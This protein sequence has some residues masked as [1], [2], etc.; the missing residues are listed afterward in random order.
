MGTYHFTL[1]RQTT[2]CYYVCNREG[3]KNGYG[4]FEVANGD[5]YSGNFKKGKRYGTGIERFYTGER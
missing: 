3:F 4:V 1:S 2:K 5:V